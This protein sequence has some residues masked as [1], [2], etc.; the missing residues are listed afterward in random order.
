MMKQLI[1][2]FALVLAIGP[3]QAETF[4]QL[5]FENARGQ[6]IK[7]GP[8]NGAAHF[9]VLGKSGKRARDSNEAW[10]K[11]LKQTFSSPDDPKVFMIADPSAR[12][13]F[14][15]KKMVKK[16][17][18]EKMKDKPAGFGESLLI[19]WDGAARK[20]LASD[21]QH[22]IYLVDSKGEVIAQAIGVYKSEKMEQLTAAAKNL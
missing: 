5:Q 18:A 14:A 17:M 16:K 8:D 12:P 21:S 20:R 7:L 11:A 1:L 4:P 2:L 6:Q 10:M 19:D 22:Y 3:A 13:P 15:S 9:V